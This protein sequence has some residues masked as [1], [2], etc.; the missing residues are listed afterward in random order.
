MPRGLRGEAVARSRFGLGLGDPLVAPRRG[1]R[2]EEKGGAEQRR[3]LFLDLDLHRIDAVLHPADAPRHRL[4][5]LAIVADRLFARDFRPRAEDR[6]PT[7]RQP[8]LLAL[9]LLAMPAEADRPVSVL[10]AAEGAPPVH[11]APR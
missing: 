6:G 8:F 7:A 4:D 5:R 2:V 1:R 10:G 11:L 9:H 3:D